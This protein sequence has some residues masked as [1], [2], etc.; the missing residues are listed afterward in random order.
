MVNPQLFL[1][2][3]QCNRFYRLNNLKKPLFERYE[4][5]LNEPILLKT[6]VFQVAG[7]YSCLAFGPPACRILAFAQS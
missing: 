7:F 2:E 4:T 6:P 1:D 5:P 3:K